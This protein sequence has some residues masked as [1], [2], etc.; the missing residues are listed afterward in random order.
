LP[1]RND[2]R[3]RIHVLLPM[4]ARNSSEQDSKMSSALA[5]DDPCC[6]TR[7]VECVWG[8]K[9]GLPF[10]GIAFF[11]RRLSLRWRQKWRDASEEK[12]RRGKRTVVTGGVRTK[13]RNS[14]ASASALLARA[15]LSPRGQYCGGKTLIIKSMGCSRYGVLDSEMIYTRADV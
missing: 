15:T 13:G 14:A 6:K 12:S 1:C 4:L 10:Y 9:N 7:A 5:I 2:R 8:G 3:I 11:S